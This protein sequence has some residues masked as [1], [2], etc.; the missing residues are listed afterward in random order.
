MS[1]QTLEKPEIIQCS[2]FL[3]KTL[4]NSWKNYW[5][6]ILLFVIQF[7]LSHTVSSN[8]SYLI[9]TSQMSKQSERYPLGHK[10]YTSIYFKWSHWV[11]CSPSVTL[12][13]SYCTNDMQYF[14]YFL[15]GF[16]KCLEYT[17]LFDPTNINYQGENL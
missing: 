15:Q 14:T 5:S 4:V 10:Q 8:T 9:D 1:L 3:N 12:R 16:R 2:Y 6:K 13:S 11:Y 7:C 17:I